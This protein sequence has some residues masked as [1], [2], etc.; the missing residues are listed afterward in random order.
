MQGAA[1][2]RVTRGTLAAIVAIDPAG[3]LFSFDNPQDRVHHT[4]AVYVESILTDI[5]QLAFSQ[6]IAH[7]SFYANWVIIT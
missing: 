3:P 1:G 7:A 2:K 6:P 5:D 4:D